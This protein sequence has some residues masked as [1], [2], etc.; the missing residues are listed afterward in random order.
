VFAG[1]ETWFAPKVREAAKA[2][3][4]ADRIRFLGFV[5]D[6]DLLHLYNACD[7]F[8][9]PSFYEGFGLPILEAMACGRAVTCSN[10][11][12]M[13]EVADGAAILFNPKSRQEMTRAMADLLRDAELRA[14]MERLGQQ[15][16]AHFSWQKSARQTLEVYYSVAEGERQNRRQHVHAS[17]SS[18]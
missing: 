6:Q 15:R 17:I 8:V 2:S 5:S 11:S 1:K 18:Q 16:A 10:T 14:R 12:A 4:V 3:G 9:F 13:P 7:L